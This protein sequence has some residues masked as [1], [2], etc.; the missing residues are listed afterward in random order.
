[1]LPFSVATHDQ[2][3]A[4]TNVNKP[5]KVEL[6]Q[7]C[8]MVVYHREKEQQGRR[9]ELAGSRVRIGRETD[10]DLVLLDEGISRHHVRIERHKAHWLVMDVGSRNGTLLNG[11]PLRGVKRL[12]NGD[13]LK[14]GSTIIKYLSGQDLESSMYEEMFQQAVTD[15]LTHLA[16]RRR[17]D[18]ELATE[19]A[20]VRRHDRELS[21]LMLDV[22]DFKQVNDR[23]GHPTGDAVLFHVAQLIRERVRGH[24]L[25]ARIG[26][27]ELAVLMPETNLQGARVLAEGLRHAI[28]QHVVDFAERHV[29]VTVSVGCAQFSRDDADPAVFV[30][31]CDAQLYAAKAAGKNR[32]C[33]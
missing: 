16:N 19:T 31:R 21:L 33:G 13:L 25:A 10:N 28:E 30:E 11:E 5:I 22:D 24:D 12:K 20:R 3:T 2:E 7:D 15:G 26:G 9:L 27:E 14:M 8:L 1:V 18:E 23:Y 29:R 4:V 32:V 6:Q 17:F